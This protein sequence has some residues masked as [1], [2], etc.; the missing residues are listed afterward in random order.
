MTLPLRVH[1]L[2]RPPIDAMLMASS[3]IP[4][5]AHENVT[6]DGDRTAVPFPRAVSRIVT[7]DRER[8]RDV[9]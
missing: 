3:L 6:D 9:F 8:K 7:C 2:S 5:R 4:V 1:I